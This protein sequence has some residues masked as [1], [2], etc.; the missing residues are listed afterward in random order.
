MDELAVEKIS[1]S[2]REDP[3][4]VLIATMLSAQTKDAVTHAASTRLFR[5][6]RSPRAMAALPIRGSSGSIYPVSFYRKKARHVQAACRQLLERFDGRVPGRDGGA[7]DAAGRRPQDGEPRADPVARQPRQHLRGHARAPH[8]E[9]ARLGADDARPSRP[10]TRCIASSPRRWW[11]ASI[12]I[13]SRGDR[14]SAVP[15]IRAAG[16]ARSLRSVR[17]SASPG[18]RAQRGRPLGGTTAER[19]G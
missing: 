19:S 9:P 2:S 8:R 6:A 14:T 10:S 1:E 17:S 3:F 5:V 12:C 18:R 11:P 4:Q 15:S 7:A 16:P 13:W